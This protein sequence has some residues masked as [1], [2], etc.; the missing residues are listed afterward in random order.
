[1]SKRFRLPIEWEFCV[2]LAVTGAIFLSRLG[3]TR[4]TGEEPRR[5]QVAREM[6][7]SGD[8][9]VPRQQG[10]PF[11]SRPPVQNWLIALVA[12]IR[13]NID[14]ITIR[15]PS[16]LAMVATAAMIYGYSRTFM[17]RMAALI[18][19]LA[20]STM[21][22]VLQ[23][24]W[25]GET[26]S[27]Y[28]FIVAGSLIFWR[29]ADVTNK[30]LL[31]V[32]SV[33]YGLA[34]LGML[35]KG[36]QAPVY[37]VGG[38]SLFLVYQRRFRDIFRWQHAVGMLLFLAIWLAWEIP[39]YRIVGK[40][41]AWVMLMG[42]IAMRFEGNG[43][44][45]WARHLVEFPAG[46]IVSTLPWSALLLAFFHKDFRQSIVAKRA[47]ISFLALSAGFAF[48]TCLVTP[49]TRNRY[50]APALPLLAPLIGLVAGRCVES[51]SLANLQLMA[52]RFFLTHALINP[53]AAGWIVAVTCLKLGPRWGQQ[54][55]A[56]AIVYAVFAMISV[57]TLLW[58]SKKIVPL[59]FM[60][61]ALSIA[62]FLG[63][64]ETGVLMN[65]FADLRQPIGESIARLNTKLP[66]DVHLVSIG[67]VDDIF[68]YY[69]AKPITRLPQDVGTKECEQPWEYF[70]MGCGPNLPKVTFDYEKLAE[71]SV[72]AGYNDHPH[73][74]VIVGRRLPRNI[75]QRTTDT[76]R[77]Y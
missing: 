77:G 10:C 33:G 27:V 15:L 51:V 6:I 76:T 71:V 12:L 32:W 13:G 47:D 30:P 69:Y 63:M 66:P 50:F 37:F 48:L 58:A 75:A 54:P 3:A 18:A 8:W 55:L 74:K 49:S 57:A 5:G 68:I 44:E 23:F 22:L 65:V 67:P 41:A 43:F 59:R 9:I 28:T 36:L 11:L 72:E 38:V 19:G 17:D 56:F 25:L 34:A 42:D 7:E 26:E 20:F 53:F 14:A 35:T 60:A 40:D 24:G 21:F 64:T 45:Q 31:L 61:G 29:W 1:M 73:D 46:L 70:C 52:R 62:I 16:G 39:F 4:P 2:L